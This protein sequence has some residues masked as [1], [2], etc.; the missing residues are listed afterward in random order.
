MIWKT[1]L[2][3]KKKIKGR[4]Y[5]GSINSADYPRINTVLDILREQGLEFR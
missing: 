5:L 4:F 3:N 1:S 2:R